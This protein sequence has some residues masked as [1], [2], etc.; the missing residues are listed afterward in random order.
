MVRTH[1]RCPKGERLRMGFPH[2][3]CKTTTLVS[4][5]RNLI[6][7]LVDLFLPTECAHYLRPCRY[8][9]DGSKYAL[10][11]GASGL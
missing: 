11:P 5:L 1:G 10:N 4:G 8:E 2:G 6:G 7:R 3:H 9:P